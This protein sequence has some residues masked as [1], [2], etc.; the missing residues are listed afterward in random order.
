MSLQLIKL[1]TGVPVRDIE[2]M[3]ANHRKHSAGHCGAT[4]DIRIYSIL[5]SD[6]IQALYKVL[7]DALPILCDDALRMEL[8]TLDQRELFMSHA[9]DG[10]VFRPCCDLK[11]L[12]NGVTLD[13]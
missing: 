1:M 9:H 12:G 6:S 11:V 5:L 10:P 7:H 4:S 3:T 8:H 13:D 2:T